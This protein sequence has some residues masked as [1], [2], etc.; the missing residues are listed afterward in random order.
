MFIL[1][2][3]LWDFSFWST[4]FDLVFVVVIQFITM[5]HLVV[6]RER[7]FYWHL[8]IATKLIM[9][10]NRMKFLK[11]NQTFIFGEI[12]WSNLVD[13]NKIFTLWVQKKF[14]N[15]HG[16]NFYLFF[17]NLFNYFLNILLIIY[18]YIYIYL[19]IYYEYILQ[20]ILY[21]I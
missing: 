2:T 14:S 13:Q 12:T 1:F 16:Q 17:F 20:Q 6:E 4:K 15:F 5:A 9:E 7:L 19:Y 21:F 8:T 18:I 3:K 11:L 10:L